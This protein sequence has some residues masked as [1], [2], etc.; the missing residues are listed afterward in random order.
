MLS[1]IAISEGGEELVSFGEVIPQICVHICVCMYVYVVCVW[2]VYVW[3]SACLCMCACVCVWCVCLC[4]QGWVL[5]QFPVYLESV[6]HIASLAQTIRYTWWCNSLSHEI[7]L[8]ETAQ[9]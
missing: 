3:V 8:S 1:L 9:Y 5:N 2:R 7:G 4:S 6:I